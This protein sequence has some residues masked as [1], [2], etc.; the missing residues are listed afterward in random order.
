MRARRRGGNIG[1]GAI[2][3]ASLAL[4]SCG[5]RSPRPTNPAH[6]LGSI[7]VI[8]VVVDSLLGFPDAGAIVVAPLGAT[9]V[10]GVAVGAVAGMVATGIIDALSQSRL[11]KKLA[12]VRELGARS[13]DRQAGSCTRYRRPIV[14]PV[15]SFATTT[16]SSWCTTAPRPTA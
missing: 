5:P 14:G 15:R 6:E 10:G 16:T 11:D 1:R 4:L 2:A 9:S 13:D 8:P 3:V 7:T 12:P